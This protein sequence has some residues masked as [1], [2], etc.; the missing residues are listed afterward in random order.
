MDSLNLPVLTQLKVRHFRCFDTLECEFAPRTNFIIGPNAQGKTS[1][2]E[3][4]CVLIRLQTPRGAT[5]TRAIQHGKT[6]FVLDGYFG[7]RHLQFYFSQQRKKL[8]LD[9]VEQKSAHEYLETAKAVW[10]SNQDIELVQG[11]ADKRRKFLDFVAVQLDRGYRRHLRD[12]EKALRSRNY[13]L[14]TSRP[15]WREIEAF[16]QPLIQAGN[17][18]I[19]AR[20]LLI[21]KLIPFALESQ[22]IISGLTETLNLEY[23]QSVPG[24]FAVTLAESREEDLRLHQTSKGPHRDDLGFSLNGVGSEF[25]SEGQ[26][27]SMVL[28]LKLAQARLIESQAGVSPVL[29][30]DDIFGELDVHRRNAL[31]EH[32]P[33][34]S[35]KLITTTHLDWLDQRPEGA[36]FSM[37]QGTIQPVSNL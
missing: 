6:G 16:N 3:A 11:A 34:D 15:N 8:A 26:Q 7:E 29:F 12:Y 18:L 31:L 32:L 23:Q 1:L 19:S 17:G 37:N 28:S 22:R 25:A 20:A 27:R 24:D 2:L 33:S 9:S 4:A 5:L 10:F 14:K 36:L 21:E 35:Q 13:L 30:L